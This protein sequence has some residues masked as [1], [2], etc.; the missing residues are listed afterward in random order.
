ML[1]AFLLEEL[2]HQCLALV[3]KHAC[4]DCTF[5]M[6]GLRC[7]GLKTPLG[8]SCAEHD[9]GDL[10]PAYSAC[11]HDTRLNGDVEGATLQVL[12]VECLGGGGDGLHLGVGGHVVE[13]LREVM[14]ATDDL[15]VGY[16]H[17]THGYLALVESQLRFVQRHGH[18]FLI[19]AHEEGLFRS[20]IKDY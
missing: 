12:A 6:Q 10:R 20:T 5:G 2:L 11:A 4:R 13:Q 7:K 15:I 1:L 8:V 14:A 9:T 18:K 16:D 19:R 3:G 17:A